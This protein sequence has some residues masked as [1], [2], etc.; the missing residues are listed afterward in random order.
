MAYVTD[1]CLNAWIDIGGKLLLF[2]NFINQCAKLDGYIA[3][4]Y[5]FIKIRLFSFHLSLGFFPRWIYFKSFCSFCKLSNI[6]I[7]VLD[8]ETD[9]ADFSVFGSLYSIPP[10]TVI[11]FCEIFIIAFSKSISLHLKPNISPL[12][13]PVE[14]AI[15]KNAWYLSKAFSNRRVK[16]LFNSSLSYTVACFD[17]DLGAST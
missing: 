11:A 17:L 10:F 9:P 16:N 7:T 3:F 14:N 13:R 2:V 6:G 5:L 15:K 8:K 4:P 1:M 12:L